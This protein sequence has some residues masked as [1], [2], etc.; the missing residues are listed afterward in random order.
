VVDP[1]YVN[2]AGPI[3]MLV[4]FA[5]SALIYWALFT[6]LRPQAPASAG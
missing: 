2:L 5:L 1:R 3:A 4:G 6:V